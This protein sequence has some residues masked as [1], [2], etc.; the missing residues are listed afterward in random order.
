ML[1][2]DSIAAADTGSTTNLSGS[3]SGATNVIQT[4]YGSNKQCTH[5]ASGRDLQV[6]MIYDLNCTF[7]F[8]YEK[9]STMLCVSNIELNYLEL[10]YCSTAFSQVSWMEIEIS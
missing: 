6:I 8:V 10:Y 5:D 4:T 1:L 2:Q 3:K 9:I 7:M